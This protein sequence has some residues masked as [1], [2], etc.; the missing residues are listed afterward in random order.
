EPGHGHVIACFDHCGGDGVTDAGCAAGDERLADHCSAGWIHMALPP[1]ARMVLQT[2]IWLQ[3]SMR[4]VQMGNSPASTPFVRLAKDRRMLHG[5]RE[6]N[7]RA[8]WP[9]TWC[10]RR[11][12]R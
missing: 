1:P 12:R 8:A 11:P 10:S 7:R 5:E 3:A 6:D 2:G 4:R 9:R